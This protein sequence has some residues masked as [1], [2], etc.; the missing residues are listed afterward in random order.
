MNKLKTQA[1]GRRVLRRSHLVL[2]PPLLR[3]K[4]KKLNSIQK[5]LDL[6]LRLKEE[7]LRKNSLIAPR[8]TSYS[9]KV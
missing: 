5:F 4:L 9:I 3:K 7:N 2:E 1:S 6:K 8:K